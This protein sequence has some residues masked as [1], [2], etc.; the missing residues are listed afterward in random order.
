MPKQIFLNIPVKDLKK[1]TDFFTKLGFR[2]NPQ[3]SNDRGACMVISDTIYVMILTEPFFKEFTKKEIADTSKENE[4]ILCLSADSK[5]EVDTMIKNALAAGA[6]DPSE[7]QD[8]GWMYNRGFKDLDGH[9]W[10][11]TYMDMSQMPQE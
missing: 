11:F 1:S 7:I 6:T 3:F 8:Y 9:A 4:V 5:E 2:N 10:E